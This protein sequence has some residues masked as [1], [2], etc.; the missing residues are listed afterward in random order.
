MKNTIKA[1]I[2]VDT[3]FLNKA[4]KYSVKIRVYD[5]K[6]SHRY[7]ALKKY[8]KEKTLNR[9][10]IIVQRESK[11]IEEINYINKNGLDLEKALSVIKNGI[12]NLTSNQERI[13]LLEQELAMLKSKENNV[14]FSEY[15][16]EFI[17]NKIAKK[18]RIA[19]FKVLKKNILDFY[20]D[21]YLIEIDYNFLDKYYNYTK[22]NGN[23][24]SYFKLCYSSLRQ[25]YYDALKR[26]KISIT[27]N[28]FLSN[29][30]INYDLKTDFSLTIEEMKSIYENRN[31]LRPKI[32]DNYKLYRSIDLYL[33]LFAIGGHNYVELSHLKWSNINKGRLEFYRQK[34]SSNGKA[35][36]IS[37][38]LF[39]FALEII[40]KYGT[41]DSEYIFDFIPDINKDLNAYNKDLRK[42]WVF[43][44]ILK[45]ELNISKVIRSNSTRHTFNTIAY[46]NLTSE[47]IVKRIQGHKSKD[48]TFNY[49]GRLDYN[50]QDREHKKIIDAVFGE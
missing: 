3:R 16:D 47:I 4:N 20:G 28:P 7:I 2:I 14:S 42:F 24:Y 45:K 21:F 33:F 1:E 34:L 23:K 30:F 37:N 46:N 17:N 38:N 9:D 8:Q 27:K 43:M 19:V 29:N 10:V 36:F 15:I 35:E 39:P 18:Q 48:M 26:G 41:K 40:E 22:N 49:T 31:L 32:I 6:S 44:G 25:L 13:Q 11:L 5:G 12:P 50:V